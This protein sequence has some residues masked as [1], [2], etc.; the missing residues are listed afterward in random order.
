MCP[1]ACKPLLLCKLCWHPTIYPGEIARFDFELIEL[2]FVDPNIL[3]DSSMAD[4]KK[5]GEPGASL[6][7]LR[8][9]DRWHYRPGLCNYVYLY[10]SYSYC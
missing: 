3:C 8:I 5:S 2:G 7:G 4:S 9:S 10:I 6:R 1:S